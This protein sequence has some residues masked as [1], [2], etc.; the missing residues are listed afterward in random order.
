MFPFFSRSNL[1]MKITNNN[2]RTR[3]YFGSNHF[4]QAN[5]Q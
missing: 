2:E 3:R 1:L 4:P 5:R